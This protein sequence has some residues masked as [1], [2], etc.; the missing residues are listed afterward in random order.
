MK[1]VLRGWAAVIVATALLL[2]LW[3]FLRWLAY[4]F[5]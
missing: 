5:R 4:Y 2:I 1:H 3:V